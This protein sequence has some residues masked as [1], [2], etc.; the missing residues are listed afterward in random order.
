[1]KILVTGGAGFIGSHIVDA[2]I[3]QSHQV[4][5]VDDLSTGSPENLHPEAEFY[6]LDIGS[7]QIL[8]LFKE[9]RFDVVFHLAAQTMIPISLQKPAHDWNI[10]VLGSLNIISACGQSGVK[11]LIFSSSAAVYGLVQGLPV[12]ETAENWPTSF[13][14]MSKLAVEKY[15]GFYQLFSGLEYI[16]LRYANVFG[17]RQGK[18]GE[19]GV[20][21]IFIAN[22]VHQRSI[23]I[24]GDGYQ[25]RDFIYISDVVAAN[26]CSLYTDKINTEYNISTQTETRINDLLSELETLSGKTLQLDYQGERPGDVLRSSLA[27]AKAQAGLGWKPQISFKD[28]LART[29]HWLKNLD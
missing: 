3:A 10:N 29:Y 11:R 21:S 28:G 19:G 27:N 7:S 26:L 23:K 14:G 6:Q 25:T 2:L 9:Q 13:Y 12:S 4:C 22:Q 17:E 15:L 24:F 8:K 1:M 20:V 16:I 18:G 5:V